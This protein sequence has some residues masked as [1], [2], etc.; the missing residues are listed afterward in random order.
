SAQVGASPGDVR[1]LLEEGLIQKKLQLERLNTY[2]LTEKGRGVVSI[3]AME[4]ERARIPASVVLDALELVVGFGDLKMAIALSVEA[5]RR[6]HFLLE[7]PP[8]CSK[9]VL[10]EGVRAAVPDAYVAFGSRTSAAGLADVLFEHQPSVLLLDEL[11]KMRVD[12]YAVLL[13]LME[14]GEILETKSRK[15]RGIQLNTLVLAAC[16]S[17]ARMPPELLSRFALHARFPAYTRAE[18]V[19]V[20]EG[21]LPRT[22]GCPPELARAIAENVFDHGLGDVRQARA[23]WQ[24]MVEPT[25]QEAQRV[26]NLKLKYSGNG[27]RGKTGRERM[28]LL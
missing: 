6:T 9:S 19:A 13:G 1:R 7:G 12:S 21:F 3:A 16:N 18:F 22:E 20:C 24:L 25:P 15:V 11:D 23:V 10:L 28:S 14:H 26:L 5:R 27:R 4:H 8:A 17:S 2:L